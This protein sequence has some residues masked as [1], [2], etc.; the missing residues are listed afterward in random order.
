MPGAQ[1][2]HRIFVNS[3]EDRRVLRGSTLGHSSL[4]GLQYPNSSLVVK[5]LQILSTVQSTSLTNTF[6]HLNITL[7]DVF[8]Q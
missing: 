7:F 4:S 8:L 1:R 3:T 5:R 2:G 6:K